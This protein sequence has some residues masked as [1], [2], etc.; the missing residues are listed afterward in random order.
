MAESKA[1]GRARR[2]R[3]SRDEGLAGGLDDIAELVGGDSDRSRRFLGGLVVGALVGAAVA[4]AAFV[5]AHRSIAE[6]PRG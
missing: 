5:R 1:R 3:R 6:E 2:S 4:G